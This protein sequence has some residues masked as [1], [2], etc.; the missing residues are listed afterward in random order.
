MWCD[1]DLLL[2]ALKEDLGAEDITAQAI[3]P[4]E[5]KVSAKIICKEEGILSGT[6]YVNQIFNLLD[7][8]L[9]LE[10][11]AHDGDLVKNKQKVFF[12][13]GNAQNILA[14]ER[15]ALNLLQ[16][17]S[18]VATQTHHLVKL[19]EG[20]LIEILDTR[21]T[22]PLWRKAQKEAVLHGGGKNHR[23]GLFDRFLIKEN[24]IAAVGSLTLAVQSCKKYRSHVLI[25]VETT[26]LAEVEEALNTEADIIMLD[27]FPNNEMLKAAKLIKKQSHKKVE[28]SGNIT[29]ERILQIKD[30]PIDYISVGALTHSVKALDFSL[31]LFWANQ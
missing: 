24:H 29:K 1:K 11:F 21:K 5:R 17:L 2:K 26:C 14:G 15:L 13:E 12:I 28:V 16:H 30:Y 25:E 18:G 8:H 9:T 31:L 27:N 10:W 6:Q 7:P 4:K 3:I 20:T 22:F 19:L 23:F